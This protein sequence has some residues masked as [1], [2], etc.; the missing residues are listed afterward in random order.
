MKICRV[1]EEVYAQTIQQSHSTF[2]SFPQRKE[3]VD[4]ELKKYVELS[5]ISLSEVDDVKKVAH[6][7]QHNHWEVKQ[8]MD[9]YLTDN[10]YIGW[11]LHLKGVPFVFDYIDMY[12]LMVS[13]EFE[14][15]EEKY[16]F[17]RYCETMSVKYCIGLILQS[18]D[19]ERQFSDV[20]VPKQ[21]IPNGVD[22]ERFKSTI[23][24]KS[25]KFRL[26][27]VGKITEW[28]ASL[29]NVCEA[30]R[31]LDVEFKVIGDGGLRKEIEEK[32]PPNVEFVGAVPYEDVPKWM[33]SADV[34]MFCVDDGS[35]V[36]IGE[37]CACGKPIITLKG[38]IE[39]LLKNS[40]NGLLVY[41]TAQEF[42]QAIITMKDDERLRTECSDANRVLSE[43]L[44][45]KVLVKRY[46][47]FI[48]ECVTREAV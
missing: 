19:L 41:D 8:D 23:V 32:S 48:K 18:G 29:Q 2:K 31:G 25:E 17:T 40:E 35:P 45:W 22:I 44:D 6:Q 27:F 26:V 20:K 42:R 37:Y 11:L 4:G 33:N 43:R 7:H 47:D 3:F 9:C 38:K 12:S 1:S 24:P 46:A 14:N 13:R 28:Y 15:D 36:V 21:V 5:N 30:V 39:W 16:T 10:P 34:C